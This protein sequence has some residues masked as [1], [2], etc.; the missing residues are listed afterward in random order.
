MQSDESVHLLPTVR[1]SQIPFRCFRA[2][3]QNSRNFSFQLT[4][5]DTIAPRRHLKLEEKFASIWLS[6]PLRVLRSRSRSRIMSS[7]SYWSDACKNA[8]DKPLQAKL[9]ALYVSCG[10]TVR[11]DC[12]AHNQIVCCLPLC[13]ALLSRLP[14]SASALWRAGRCFIGGGAWRR[15]I[16]GACGGCTDGSL[17]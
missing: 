6:A 7:A 12:A 13:D 4:C 17:G 5:Q 3:K 14:S 8:I 1:V 16:G 11:P 15:R 9:D 2:K 10:T